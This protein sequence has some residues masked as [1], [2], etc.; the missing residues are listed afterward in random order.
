M[1]L[2]TSVNDRAALSESKYREDPARFAGRESDF[3][4]WVV[5]RL[6][7]W[8][9]ANL[10]ELGCGAGRDLTYYLGRGYSALGVDFAPTAI[11]RARQRVAMLPEPGRS[12][13]RV[14]LGEALAVLRT[15]PE[16]SLEAVVANGMYATLPPDDLETLVSEIGR[17]VRPGGLHAYAVRTPSDPQAGEGVRVAPDTWFGGPHSAPYRYF[18]TE[19]I[20]RLTAA[21]FERAERASRGPE[22]Q[23]FVADRRR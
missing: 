7:T 15:L 13:G 9:G 14:A 11:E 20:E 23:V 10:V 2:P 4:H 19:V 21:P 1:A 12:R 22:H 3:A 18:S 16:Q 8:K 6:P 5:E 17:C